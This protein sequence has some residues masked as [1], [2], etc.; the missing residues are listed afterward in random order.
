MSLEMIDFIKE[1]LKSDVEVEKTASTSS[2]E[3]K[4]T[5]SDEVENLASDL[6][7]LAEDLSSKN[8]EE[9]VSDEESEEEKTA[10]LEPDKE[11]V[12]QALINKIL[13]SKDLVSKLTETK[14]T[15]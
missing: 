2:L 12:R 11:L 3:D 14:E 7:K 6:E 5:I 1:S 4:Q 15:E 10:S 13:G 8:M 9:V